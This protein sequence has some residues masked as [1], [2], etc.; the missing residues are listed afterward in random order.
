MSVA[1]KIVSFMENVAA[2]QSHGYSQASRWGNPDYDCSSLVITA[3]K[4]A[5]I[6]INATY[7]GDMYPALTGAGFKDVKKNVNLA[8]GA[9]LKRG[10][11]LLNTVHHT[12]VYCGDGKIVHARGQSLG[13]P[14]PGDQGQEISVSNYYNYPWDYVLRYEKGETTNKKSG[15]VG[16]CNIELYQM[17]KG[18]TGEQ[19]KTLQTLLK[20]KGYKGSD[21]KNLIID[22]E[23][24]DN[25]A[26]AVKCLQKD[27]NFPSTTYWGTVAAKTWSVLL[28]G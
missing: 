3:V 22:G 15:I 2:D 9:G 10:D 12:A 23:Y 16:T 5:G 13:S 1:E 6:P 4:K 8:T 26:Y 28:K 7:T 25:T 27:Y 14:S 11:I 20:Q 19:V 21:G 17:V 18:A 24:G